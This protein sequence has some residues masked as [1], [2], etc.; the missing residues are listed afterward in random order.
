MNEFCA[1]G[2]VNVPGTISAACTA[3]KRPSATPFVMYA[4][5]TFP[6]CQSPPTKTR[7]AL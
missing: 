7:F 5:V 2:I 6:P 4:D 3:V 1:L